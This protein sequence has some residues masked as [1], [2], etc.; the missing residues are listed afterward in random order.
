MVLL[1]HLKSSVI[2]QAF[3]F[4]LF[5]MLSISSSLLFCCFLLL[6]QATALPCCCSNITNPVVLAFFSLP[7]LPLGFLECLVFWWQYRRRYVSSAHYYGEKLEDITN[8]YSE[9]KR[10][11]N[12]IHLKLISLVGRKPV[13]GL[14]YVSG[15]ANVASCDAT[16]CRVYSCSVYSYGMIENACTFLVAEKTTGYELWKG[17]VDTVPSSFVRDERAGSR[18][19]FPTIRLSMPPG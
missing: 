2:A 13:S 3:L 12:H 5:S 6:Q 11:K 7:S 4:Q 1:L 14:L 8:G 18:K 15:L 19:T 16:C 10:L 9:E 17:E